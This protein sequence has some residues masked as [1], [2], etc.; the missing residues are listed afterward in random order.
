[1]R[2]QREQMENKKKNGG[3]V[4]LRWWPTTILVFICQQAELLMNKPRIFNRQD[5]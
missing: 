4:S 2:A 5:F 1:M 3:S